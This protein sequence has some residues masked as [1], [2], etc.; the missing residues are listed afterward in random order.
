MLIMEL[1]PEK[2]YPI[3]PPKKLT[4]EL[5]NKSVIVIKEVCR[6]KRILTIMTTGLLAITLSAGAAWAQTNNSKNEGVQTGVKAIEAY[7]NQHKATLEGK[8]TVKVYFKDIA[9][10][11][12]SVPIKRVAGMWLF[13]GYEDGTFRPDSTVSQAEMIVLLMRLVDNDSIVSD[14][15]YSEKLKE[16]PGWARD[17]VK[18]A[19]DLKVMSLDRFHPTQQASRAQTCVAFA[20]ALKLAPIDNVDINFADQSLIDKDDLKYI[21]AMYQAV[22]ITGTQGNYFLP[23]YNIT[24]AEMATIMDR[25]LDDFK[26]DSGGEDIVNLIGQENDLGNAD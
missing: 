24:R 9:D 10:H 17:S 21:M 26:K 7:E 20:K 6:L 11:W 18:K 3:M 16:V 19:V 13:S 15:I 12:A 25:V 23:E 1:A 2:K 5:I 22:Y 8:F 14:A 4:Y